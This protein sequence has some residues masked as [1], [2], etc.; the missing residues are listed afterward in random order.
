MKRLQEGLREMK[1]DM[2]K[3]RE[4]CDEKRRRIAKY[5]DLNERL[6]EALDAKSKFIVMI[7]ML[8]TNVSYI[9]NEIQKAEQ[10]YADVLARF[11]EMDLSPEQVAGMAN[12]QVELEKKSLSNKAKINELEQQ[13]KA[14]AMQMEQMREDVSIFPETQSDILTH[15]Q[16]QR[17]MHEYNSEATEAGLIPSTAENANGKDYRF[18]FNPEGKTLAEMSSVD[19]EN[20]LLVSNMHC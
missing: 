4:F 20:D 15:M 3:Y 5:V 13:Y 18:V 9:E 16:I 11:K 2:A 10:D 19:W 8:G 12:E 6:K 1:E 14:R 17:D 7:C